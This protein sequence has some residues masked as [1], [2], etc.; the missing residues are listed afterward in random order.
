M[1]ELGFAGRGFL[2]GVVVRVASMR[3]RNRR[4]WG[5]ILSHLSFVPVA[6]YSSVSGEVGDFCT[7]VRGHRFIVFAM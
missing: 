6:V 4:C 2:C 1:V 7:G 5:I 3:R